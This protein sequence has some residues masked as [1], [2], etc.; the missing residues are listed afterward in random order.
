MID[1]RYG[2][3]LFE[4]VFINMSG[5]IIGYIVILGLIIFAPLIFI[6][7]KYYMNELS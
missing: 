4:S 2:K 6:L 7:N 1:R 3:N 5:I